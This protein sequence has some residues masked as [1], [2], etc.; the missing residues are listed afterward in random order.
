MGSKEMHIF[1]KLVFSLFMAAL[2]T[3]TF[4]WLFGPNVFVLFGIFAGSLALMLLLTFT[5][6]RSIGHWLLGTQ[7]RGAETLS[8]LGATVGAG[9]VWM[10][11]LVAKSG[12]QDQL[13]VGYGV[14]IAIFTIIGFV[15]SFLLPGEDYDGE[16]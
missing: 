11:S 9:L 10:L 16:D 8:V 7:L 6:L 15:G 12:D 13:M 1:Y 2:T 3:L 14:V 4:H 5:S